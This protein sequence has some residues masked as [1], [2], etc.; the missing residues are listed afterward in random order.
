MN[1]EQQYDP[2]EGATEVES[3]DDF[4]ID[5]DGFSQDDVSSGSG[6]VNKKGK[7]HFEVRQ[8]KEDL[9]LEKLD[10]NGKPKPKAPNVRFDLLVCHCVEGQ[11]PLGALH[12]H[13]VYVGGRGG[14]AQSEGGRK[15]T[16]AWCLALGLAKEVTLPPA[17][18]GEE[19]RTAIVDAET[20]KSINLATMRRGVGKHVI[21]K[22]LG[23]DHIT[24]TCHPE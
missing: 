15:I 1:T 5:G 17:N 6:F 24:I 18:P 3:I 12:L 4:N 7:Y 20:G 14:K 22:I 13:R 21:A 9:E 23:C 2:F 10:D 8:I 19:G 16:L 11:S